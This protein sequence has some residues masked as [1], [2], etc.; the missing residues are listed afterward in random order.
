MKRIITAVILSLLGPGLGQI[1]NKDYKKGAALLA[2]ST[3]LIFLPAIW[4]AREVARLMPQPP[5]AI[6][7]EMLREI[8][9]TIAT[10]NAHVLN[11]I[12][13]TF[14]GIWAYAITQAYFKA[15]EISESETGTQ[16]RNSGSGPTP[17][18]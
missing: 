7:P 12:S 10:Q 14:L 5:D 16:D 3:L 4:L 2:V 9:K 18:S 15:K 6:Q 11:I 17:A 8:T 13:F 1:Y